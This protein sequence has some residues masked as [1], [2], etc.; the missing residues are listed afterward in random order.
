MRSQYVY[1]LPHMFLLVVFVEL[2]GG[3]IVFCFFLGLV[4]PGCVVNVN[5]VSDAF[6][7]N[8]KIDLFVTLETLDVR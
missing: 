4:K 6:A 2:G 8:Q 3:L 1:Y 7:T 5:S